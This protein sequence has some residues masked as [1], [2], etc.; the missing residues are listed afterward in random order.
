MTYLTSVEV[1]FS[2]FT[3]SNSVLS[4]QLTVLV[5]FGELPLDIHHHMFKKNPGNYYFPDYLVEETEV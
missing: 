5:M 2:L 3:G 4:Y 1:M